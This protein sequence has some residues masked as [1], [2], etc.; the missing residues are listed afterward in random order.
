[1]SL[2]VPVVRIV[3]TQVLDPHA[4]GLRY[5][6]IH[7]GADK[8]SKLSFNH[9]FGLRVYEQFN[10][11]LWIRCHN[12]FV[13]PEPYIWPRLHPFMVAVYERT[14][15]SSKAMCSIL[16]IFF[17]WSRNCR[18]FYKILIATTNIVDLL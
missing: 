7:T 6:L 5:Q 15:F 8:P 4:G 18:K 3:G 13:A 16:F 11:T 17:Y 2:S 12:V 1:V 10:A 14:W 9:T